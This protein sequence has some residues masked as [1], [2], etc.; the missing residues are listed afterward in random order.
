[1]LFLLHVEITKN[2][3]A[4]HIFNDSKIKALDVEYKIFGD[5]HHTSESWLIIVYQ[6]N[7][8]GDDH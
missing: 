2:N 4:K 5:E 8:R 1:M 7:I 3:F 6:H